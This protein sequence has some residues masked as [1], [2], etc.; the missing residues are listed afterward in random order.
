MFTLPQILEE[1]INQLNAALNDL[2]QKSEATTALIIDKGGF[3]V[4]RCGRE[5]TYDATTLA[6]LA[7]ASFTA[8]QAISNLLNEPDFS[9][10][11]QQGEH[12]SMLVSNVDEYSL[13]LIIFQ[14]HI[15]VGVVKYYA[16]PAI[17]QVAHQLKIAHLRA[18]D[19][20]VDMSLLNI[21]DTSFFFKRKPSS[22]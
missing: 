2:L 16:G 4:T 5:D 11:Y 3:V 10:I 8:T 13:L 7:A 12:S 20:G 19:A 17:Q 21:A 9:S 1:D 14:A 18:P 6:A 15:N 22:P